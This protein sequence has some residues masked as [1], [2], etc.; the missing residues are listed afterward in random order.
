MYK[1][2]IIFTHVFLAILLLSNIGCEP[3]LENSEGFNTRVPLSPEGSEWTPIPDK[4]RKPYEPPDPYSPFNGPEGSAELPESSITPM[5]DRP[6]K[7]PNPQR[8]STPYGG[9]YSPYGGGGACP[10]GG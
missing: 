6:Y 7:I 9:G 5:P 8:P 4:Q 1:Y 3:E 10:P 2:C